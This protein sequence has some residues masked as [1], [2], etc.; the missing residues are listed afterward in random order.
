MNS[1]VTSSQVG[2][3]LFCDPK[4]NIYL[5]KGN[6]FYRLKPDQE[7]I[8]GDDPLKYFNSKIYW[9]QAISSTFSYRKKNK[10]YKK[11]FLTEGE[12]KG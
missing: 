10:I 2:L 1:L 11:L 3:Y 4:E 5:H 8:K 12:E 7:Q 6:L 9:L